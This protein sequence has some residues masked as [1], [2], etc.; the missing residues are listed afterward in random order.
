[1]PSSRSVPGRAPRAG[2]SHVCPNS[3]PVPSLLVW[4]PTP[5]GPPA[6]PTAP[7]RRVVGTRGRGRRLLQQH[8]LATWVRS[9]GCSY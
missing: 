6:L 2:S 7:S 9:R 4:P 8:C 3:C 5:E 1:M